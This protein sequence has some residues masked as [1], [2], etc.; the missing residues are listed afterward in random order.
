[1]MKKITVILIILMMLS[2]TA[3]QIGLPTPRNGSSSDVK[4]IL[5]GEKLDV[6]TTH[7]F[8][9]DEFV[10]IPLGAFLHSVGAEYADSP[11]NE[12]GSYC[13][14]FMS[15]RYVIIR[16]LHLFMLEEDYWEL[17]SRW[18]ADGKELT[19]ETATD[20]G[21]LPRNESKV[22]ADKDETNV[23][24]SGI[25]VDHVSLM[26]A[27]RESGIDITIVYDHSANTLTV[28]LPSQ[29]NCSNDSE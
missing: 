7:Y 20:M 24:S 19:R 29:G 5:N 11:L 27:L 10:E 3:C 6:Y 12:Y 4:L 13:Y 14:S 22:L 25:W 15:K 21:L 26:N 18:E 17:L 16:D 2:L 28:T 8:V 1:M 23:A 9:S